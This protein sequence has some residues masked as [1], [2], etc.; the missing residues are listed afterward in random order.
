MKLCLRWP[1]CIQGIR[2][3]GEVSAWGMGSH[4]ELTDVT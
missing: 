4:I 2:V 1:L 3:I